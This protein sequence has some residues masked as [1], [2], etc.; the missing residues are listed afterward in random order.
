MGELVAR[1]DVVL[2]NRDVRPGLES[3]FH[4]LRVARHFLFVP[5]GEGY[6]TVHSDRGPSMTSKGVAQMLA[7]MG[8]TQTHSRPYTSNDNPFS[9]SVDTQNRPVVDT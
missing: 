6:R 7:D 9:A 2:R 4:H 5:C 8:I 1:L 3:G